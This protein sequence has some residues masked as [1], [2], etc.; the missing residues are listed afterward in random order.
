MSKPA[1]KDPLAASEREFVAG[2][3]PK[4]VNLEES[5]PVGRPRSFRSNRIALSSRVLPD[6]LDAVLAAAAARNDAQLRSGGERFSLVDVIDEALRAWLE[7]HSHSERE[8]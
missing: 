5:K 8:G 6:L 3:K 2:T 7:Q 1:R 4:A